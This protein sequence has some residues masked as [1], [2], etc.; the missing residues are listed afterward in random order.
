MFVH[1]QKKW[2]VS[3]RQFWVIFIA[4]A[5]TGTTT[6]FITRYVATWLGLSAES[7]WLWRLLLR[8]SMLL[9]GYQVLLLMY[10]GLLG[11]WAFFWKY[12]RKLLQKLGIIKK[13]AETSAQTTFKIAIFASGAGSNAAKMIA[14]FKGH[15]FVQVALIVSNKSDAGVLAIASAN[16]IETL[17]I[18][19]ER[20]TKGDA[21]TPEL[22]EKGINF[23]VLAGFLWKIPATLIASYPNKIVNIHPALL[24]KYGGKGMYGARV[25]EAVIAAR[26]PESGIT[27]H[28]VNEH[29]DEGATIFQAKCKVDTGDTADSLAEKIH[30]LEHAHFSE[31]IERLLTNH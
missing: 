20:F 7:Y 11:Q 22:M 31:Q 2:G 23:I 29:Y 27:I 25:H 17:I 26:E 30:V 10:G 16:N 4:F 19:R 3:T 9:I 8:V 15:P 21:Y 13:G 24:P 1:L 5:L 28:W 14:Y 18:E 12:E 6:A